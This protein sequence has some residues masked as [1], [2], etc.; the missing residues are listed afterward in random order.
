MKCPRC[1]QN[2]FER[3]NGIVKCS[4]C[5]Y[6]SPP[7][8]SDRLRE[9]LVGII[10]SIIILIPLLVYLYI[11][12]TFSW[13]VFQKAYPID[14]AE[15]VGDVILY[16]I[17]LLG[18][19]DLTFIFIKRYFVPILIT[20]FQYEPPKVESEHDY[21]VTVIVIAVIVISM[22]VFVNLLKCSV[23]TC[24]NGPFTL[25]VVL[26][27]A[28]MLLIAVGIWEKYCSERKKIQI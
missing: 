14:S 5:G 3:I 17:L 18:L 4:N 9:R 7:P 27:G 23:G 16:A 15:V 2:T 13:Y 28:A 8:D 1:S 10:T 25:A 12:V 26:F 24:K 21:L 20:I 22:E 6:A 19:T 11:V